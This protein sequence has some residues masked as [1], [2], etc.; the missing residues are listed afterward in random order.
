M[1]SGEKKISLQNANIFFRWMLWK[2]WFFCR[3]Y[4]IKRWIIVR[5][6]IFSGEF[7]YFRRLSGEK[8]NNSL[9]PPRCGE[10]KNFPAQNRKSYKNV[11]HFHR[12]AIITHFHRIYRK[13]Y[14]F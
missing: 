7:F 11:T 14:I 1:K 3:I 8:K 13:A 6:A 5:F 4:C 9:L 12:I 2:R 10:N